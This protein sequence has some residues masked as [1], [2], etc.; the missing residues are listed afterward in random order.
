MFDVTYF[1][2]ILDTSW[3]GKTFLFFETIDS[4]NNY[5]KTQDP[6]NTPNGLVC[7]A[8][9]QTAGRGQYDRKWFSSPSKN[10]MYSIV[11]KPEHAERLFVLSLMTACAICDIFETCVSGTFSIKWPNDI[12]F[13]EKKLGGVL[14]ET[15]FAGNKLERLII[16]MGL[17]INEEE[18]GTDINNKAT[19]LC[20]LNSGNYFDREKLLNELLKKIEDGVER[21]NVDDKELIRQINARII[22]YGRD[23]KLSINGKCDDKWYKLLGINRDGHLM[24]LSHEL[25]VV[26]FKYEQIRVE[27]VA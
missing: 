15:V 22:G 11:L 18:F 10:L 5:I 21:W 6:A 1:Q 8:D 24:T 3:L 16:G 9:F 12:Y 14:M 27:D 26:T 13:G 4:T 17:N 19:S 2:K 25:E 7:L 23:V 20:R